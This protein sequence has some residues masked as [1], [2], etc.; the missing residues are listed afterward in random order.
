MTDEEMKKLLQ[1]EYEKGKH[2]AITELMSRARD[3]KVFK[4]VDD[5]IHVYRDKRHLRLKKGEKLKIIIL[6]EGE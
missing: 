6:K 1:T 2:D 4:Y 3:A 5:T